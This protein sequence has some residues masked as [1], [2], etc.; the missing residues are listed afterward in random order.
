MLKVLLVIV[1]A[2][3]AFSSAQTTGS[4]PICARYA[5]ALNVSQLTL[6]TNIITGVFDALVANG[7]NTL[8]FFNGQTPAGSADF[9]TN[10]T[11][12]DILANGLIEFFG[13]ALGCNDPDF[14]VYDGPSNMTRVHANMPI[15]A[16][17]FS[18]FVSDVISVINSAGVSQADQT[19]VSN[20]LNTFKSQ[21]CNQ[22]DCGNDTPSSGDY[23]FAPVVALVALFIA[24]LV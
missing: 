10:T 24:L 1:F 22:A 20:L 7:T 5:T 16:A 19:T 9:L 11:A 6:M 17:V 23:I 12:F 18:Q 21:I 3:L 2:S 8:P 14:P 13:A 15:T 4:A